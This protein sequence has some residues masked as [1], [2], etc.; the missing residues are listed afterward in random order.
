MKRFKAKKQFK[1]AFK[2]VDTPYKYKMKGPKD[3][4]TIQRSTQVK[5]TP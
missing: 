1:K 2:S 3:K 5:D 4:G